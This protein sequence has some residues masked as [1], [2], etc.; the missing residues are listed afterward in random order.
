LAAGSYL[1]TYESLTALNA[2]TETNTQYD[3]QLTASAFAALPAATAVEV[4]GYLLKTAPGSFTLYTA[5]AGQVQAA[6]T[7]Q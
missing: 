3:H 1:T 5:N 2:V 4:N 7:P 6:Q